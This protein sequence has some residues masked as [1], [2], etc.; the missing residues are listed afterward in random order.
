MTSGCQ[1]WQPTCHIHTDRALFETQSQI[2]TLQ[3]EQ[4]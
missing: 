1:T 4:T 2:T 3:M